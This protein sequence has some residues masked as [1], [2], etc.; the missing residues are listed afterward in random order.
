MRLTIIPVD[1]SVYVDGMFKDN[2]N[3]TSCGIPNGVNALQWYDTRG[4][5]EPMDDN[6]PFTPKQPNQDIF[7]LPEWALNCYQVW[8]DS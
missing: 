6:D 2:L 7:E 3:L 1:N 4:W 5:I 8:L